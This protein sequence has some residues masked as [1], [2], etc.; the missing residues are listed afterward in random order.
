MPYV[1]WEV[2]VREFANCNCNYG[3]PCQF[4]ALPTMV[5]AEPWS[6]MPLTKGTLA[7]PN[8]TAYVRSMLPSGLVLYTRGMGSYKLSLMNALMRRSV[9]PYVKSSTAKRLTQGPRC[10]TFFG[11]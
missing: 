11:R 6:V 9:R 3:C 10:G 7:I 2:K 4:N 5:I 8:L 1:E